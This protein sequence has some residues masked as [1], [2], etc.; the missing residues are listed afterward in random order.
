MF[1]SKIVA[2]Y[3]NILTCSYVVGFINRHIYLVFDRDIDSCKKKYEYF[4]LNFLNNEILDCF[5]RN[6]WIFSRML[7]TFCKN[8]IRVIFTMSKL[9]SK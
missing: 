1:L 3:H 2:T 5:P 6:N 7:F 8:V 4:Q 9:Q